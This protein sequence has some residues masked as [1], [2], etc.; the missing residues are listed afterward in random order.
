[1]YHTRKAT[2]RRDKIYTLLGINSNNTT[3]AGL[4]ADYDISWKQLFCKLIHFLLP[5]LVSVD[6]SD[7]KEITVIK[8]K[9]YILSKVSSVKRNTTWEDRQNV[10][11]TWKN[12]PSYICVKEAWGSSWTLPTTAKSVQKGNVVCLLQGASRPTILRPYIDHWAVI[13][14]A[15]S[16]AGDSQA[17][18]GDI[19]WLELLQSITVF[20]HN[21]RLE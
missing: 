15:I 9:G 21:L 4:F 10:A 1:M 3:A 7:D 2:D 19:T 12:A 11:F 17:T 6:L 20:P 8:G 18:T 13:I 14:I 16:P 5:E